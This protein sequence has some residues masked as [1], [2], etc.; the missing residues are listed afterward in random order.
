MAGTSFPGTID[1]DLGWDL[2]ADYVGQTIGLG[3]PFKSYPPTPVLAPPQLLTTGGA[4]TAAGGGGTKPAGTAFPG[5]DE[6]D[7]SSHAQDWFERMHILPRTKI[8]F[9]NIITLV[10]EDYE[11]YSAFREASVTET[12]TVINPSPGI[13]LPNNTPPVVVPRQTSMLDSTTTGQT[14]SSLGTLVKLKVQA[15]PNGLTAFDDSIDFVFPLGN[16]VQLFV[17]GSRIVLIPFDYESPMRETLAFLTE[18]IPGLSGVEQRISL[19][20]Q[21]RQLYEVVYK[22]DGNDRQRMQ[23]L[24]MD[25]TAR[26][27]GFP[28]Q[29]E[30]LLTTAA[31]S[32]GATVYQVTGADDVDL[33]VGGL[34]VIITDANTFDVIAITAKTDTTITASDP[35]LNAYP[36][37]TG[38][39]PLRTAYIRRQVAA[40]MA[41]KNLETFKV[42][43]EVTDNDTGALAGSTAA[44]STFNSKVLF[45]D[46]NVMSGEMA[47]QY[48][49]RIYRIDNKTGIVNVGSTW[50]RGKRSHQKGFVLRNRGEILDFR[51]AMLSIG[52]RWISFYM[53]T[54][55]DDLEVKATLGI[56]SDTMDIE[57]I[58]YERFVQ[59]RE[60]KITF[61]ITFTDDTSLV[62]EVQ[63][64]AEVDATTER[65]TLDTTWPATRTVDEVERV[66]F[67][68]LSRFDADNVV[69]QY[70]RIGLA[71]CQMPVLQVFDDN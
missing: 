30:K 39:M 41:Q 55:N 61:R 13:A 37:G 47:E 65:L 12:S 48:K 63:S 14:T 18:I 34:A 10:E 58:E 2:A 27:F 35:S 66:Q 9:G 62:R 7:T 56:G 28:L 64:V 69:I 31:A 20:K 38:I 1:E 11:I 3:I 44:Y 60:P 16:D 50:D 51:K 8:D 23:A 22:L 71:T 33:R 24:L 25:W 57:N 53:P 6:L 26:L 40:A 68:E 29:N 15:L 49:R 19:R 52:G 46:C 59:S 17:S 67:Y 21:P 70:P 36:V 54:F 42:V 32:V 4:V 45:D 5:A 43:F